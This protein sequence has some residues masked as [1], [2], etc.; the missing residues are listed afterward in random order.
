MQAQ[1]F[2]DMQS[3]DRRRARHMNRQEP[4]AG[5]VRSRCELTHAVVEY[6]AR[7]RAG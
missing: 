1:Q 7:A 2:A 3:Y 5:G 4:S 6:G